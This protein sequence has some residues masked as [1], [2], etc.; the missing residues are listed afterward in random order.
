MDLNS[1]QPALR[2]SKPRHRRYR[3]GMFSFGFEIV[4][5]RVPVPLAFLPSVQ[6]DTSIRDIFL[7]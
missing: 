3:S 5:R 1:Q 6:V 4:L 7:L 2:P